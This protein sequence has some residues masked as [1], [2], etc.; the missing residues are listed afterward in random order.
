MTFKIQVQKSD[1][2]TKKYKNADTL[3]YKKLKIQQKNVT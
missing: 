1:V 3:V 2:M